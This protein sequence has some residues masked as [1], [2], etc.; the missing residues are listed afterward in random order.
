MRRTDRTMLEAT[1]LGF[2]K[3]LPLG[4]FTVQL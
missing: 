3:Y 4:Y 1:M 2:L